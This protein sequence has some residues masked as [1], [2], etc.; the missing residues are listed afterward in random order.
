MSRAK[1]WGRN[2]LLWTG[3][4]NWLLVPYL[5][6]FTLQ[7]PPPACFQGDTPAMRLWVNVTRDEATKARW[8][9]SGA[10]TELDCYWVTL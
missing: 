7:T 2:I 6:L 8:R 9:A 4:F 10:F 3:A 1:R 5:I